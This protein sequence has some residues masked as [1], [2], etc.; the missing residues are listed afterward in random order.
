MLVVT[1]SN[2]Q[3]V[4][5]KF[6][7]FPAGESYTKILEIHKV[8]PTMIVSMYLGQAEE[9]MSTIML[10]NACREAGATRVILHAPYLPYSRQDRVCS[11]G[12]SNSF[13]VYL[14]LLRIVFDEVHT[15]DLHNPL[16]LT[17]SYVTN[18]L[19]KYSTISL[20]DV[21]GAIVVAPDKGAIG[22]AVAFASIF[23]LDVTTMDKHRTPTG[24]IQTINEPSKIYEAS[25]IV[26]VDDI[27]DGGRTF[28]EAAKEIR[29]FNTD[30]ILV[31]VVTH[32]IFSN[33]R[34]EL[35]KYFTKVVALNTLGKPCDMLNV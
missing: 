13:A 8:T 30:A 35:L 4:S 2:N 19:P 18:Y 22:R 6:S 14:S 21:A 9:T 34:E 24:I 16:V 25:R 7:I 3:E 27:C 20:T 5:C 10:A 17:D 12:E 31:L 11:E 28:I 26:I 23:D 15:L 1:N 33:G 29:K 32:G